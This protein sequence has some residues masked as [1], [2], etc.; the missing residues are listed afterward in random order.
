MNKIK[1]LFIFIN[2]VFILLTIIFKPVCAGGTEYDS[3]D[4]LRSGRACG[5]HV[6]VAKRIVK[7]LCEC[8]YF[9]SIAEQDNL[10]DG[11]LGF[12]LR[13]SY[14]EHLEKNY[15]DQLG[16]FPDKKAI[17]KDL[18]RLANA[19]ALVDYCNGHRNVENGVYFKTHSKVLW[20]SF[21]KAQSVMIGIL[22]AAN[23]LRNEAELKGVGG[24]I[25]KRIKDLADKMREFV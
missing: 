24:P 18:A 10:E 8:I 17:S 25:D 4:G 2:V 1:K 11:G 15:I 13:D 6:S 21:G 7:E 22:R 23:T 12:A 16:E 9:V 14:L 19:L 3:M 5:K 20:D